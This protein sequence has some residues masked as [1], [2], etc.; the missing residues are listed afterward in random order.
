MEGSDEPDSWFLSID[1]AEY[2][3]PP[4]KEEDQRIRWGVQATAP[5][6]LEGIYHI[7]LMT[8]IAKFDDE[9]RANVP[10]EVTAPLLLSPD[11]WNL[12]PVVVTDD[13]FVSGINDIDITRLTGDVLGFLSLL[14]S[15][16]KTDKRRYTADQ[17]PKLLFPIMPRTDWVGLYAQLSNRPPLGDLYNLVRV[18]ACFEYDSA[19]VLK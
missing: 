7:L 2:E 4:N 8:M 9:A 3:V 19:G 15:W 10:V 11:Y 14:L 13:F 6:P 1:S 5:M 17:S 16:V 12:R 18:L